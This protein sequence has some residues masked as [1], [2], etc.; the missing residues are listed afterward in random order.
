MPTKDSL[1]V[2]TGP[3]ASGKSAFAEGLARDQSRALVSADAFQFYKEIPT[4]SN[5]PEQA[6]QWKGIGHRSVFDDVS[7]RDFANEVGA[8]RDDYLGRDKIL[9]GTGLY[10]TGALYGFDEVGTKGTPFRGAPRV[11]SRMI[12]LSPP[13]ALLYKRINQRVDQMIAKGALAEAKNVLEQL[14]KRKSSKDY[15]SLKAIGLQH[16]IMHLQGEWTWSTCVDLWKR[17]TRRLAKRQWTWLRKFCPPSKK[18]LWLSLESDQ[19][20]QETARKF[21]T[22]GDQGSLEAL[23]RD[24]QKVFEASIQKSLGSSRR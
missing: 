7:V 3:T 24:A 5:Q 13:R 2:I 21:L 6:E 9:V 16:L 23:E 18:C 10:V 17:D 12:V 22:E 15:A 19:T 4:L 8:H 20:A 14:N 11:D 1:W